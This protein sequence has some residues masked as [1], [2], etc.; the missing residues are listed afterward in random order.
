MDPR[1]IIIALLIA[2]VLSLGFSMVFLVRDNSSRRR[3]LNALKL[4]VAL[5][6]ALIVVFAVSVLMG[7]LRPNAF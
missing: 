3:T 6:I 4:R 2:I 7:W 5:S 1:F